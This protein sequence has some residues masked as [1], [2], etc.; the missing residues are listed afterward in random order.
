MSTVTR[1]LSGVFRAEGWTIQTNPP[2]HLGGSEFDL[3][4]E[5]DV[6]IVFVAAT[7]ASDLR[8]D[9]TR[10]A[11]SIAG[12]LQRQ[13]GPKVWEAYL[14][15]VAPGLRASDDEVI[16]QVHR[17]LT[18]CRKLVVSLDAILATHDPANLLRR[19]LALLFP[20]SLAEA[21]MSVEPAGLLE[22][23]LVERGNDPEIV[24]GMLAAVSDPAFDPLAFF[25][26]RLST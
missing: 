25:A 16:S 22:R 18:Y 12:A 13:G 6:A 14:I 8:R 26:D 21:S 15:L 1:L 3:V 17:D 9:S 23:G 10:L 24:R 11:A 19:R 7:T 4:A 2:D 20:L 5:N